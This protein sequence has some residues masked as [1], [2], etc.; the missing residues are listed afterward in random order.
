MIK[1]LL[2]LL[3][4]LGFLW[5]GQ[6]QALCVLPYILQNGVIPD[7][8]QVM[9]DFYSLLNCFN[10]GGGLSSLTSAPGGCV[11]LTPDPIVLTGTIGLAVPITVP[12]GGTGDASFGVGSVLIGEGA[13]A[14]QEA[15][16]STVGWVLTD[17]GAL[18]N[19]TFQP[20]AT[21]F[22][23]AVTC[24]M[25]AAGCPS[26]LASFMPGVPPNSAIIVQAQAV[27]KT[28]PVNLAGSVA[29]AEV[30]STGNAVVSIVQI[31]GGGVGTI[32]F[33]SSATGVFASG[34][35]TIAAGDRIELSFPALADATLADIS[36]TLLCARS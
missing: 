19:P 21:G 33:A 34:G 28:C 6:A 7:A 8:T 11:T 2:P 14:L 36:I 5:G 16:P 9:A 29:F 27:A 24:V 26:E 30:A 23:P 17:N 32:T 10:S 4:F 31:P 22:P 25:L 20:P 15:P 1:R 3:G 18:T 13:A 12:C 35:I